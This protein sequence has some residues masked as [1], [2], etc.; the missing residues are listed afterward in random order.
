MAVGSV[1]Y[2]QL[3]GINIGKWE[4][5]SIRKPISL[6]IAV[7]LV[8]PN[9]WFA[10]LQWKITLKVMDLDTDLKRTVHSFFA[11]LITGMLTPNMAGNFIG[12]FYYFDKEHRGTITFLTLV[13]NYSH[14]LSTLT[15]GLIAVFSVGEIYGIGSSWQLLTFF[16][17]G[18]VVAFFLYFFI[19]K[20][21]KWFKKVQFLEMSQT[22]LREH[23]SF[24]WN[25]IWWSMARFVVFTLQSSLM[26]HAFGET[27]SFSLLLA[28]WQVYL[29]TLMAPSLF[30]GKLGVK[31]VISVG[32]L[33]SLGLNEVS[34]FFA[35][36]II[37]FVN[38]MSPALLGLIICKRPSE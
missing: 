33:G 26:L 3:S 14:L 21:L 28:I 35:S 6:V 9:I 4:N 37:W 7:I 12:R 8:V 25:L 10:Y 16:V 27:W 23:R 13:S 2:S 19:E 30:L 32:I 18:A 29:I 38:S 36:L 22:I 31:E 11:G 20:P 5:L 24:R 34:I 1:I 15:F 17:A